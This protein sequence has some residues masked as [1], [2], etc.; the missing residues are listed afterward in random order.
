MYQLVLLGPVT[1]VFDILRNISFYVVSY[2]KAIY[3]GLLGKDIE[4]HY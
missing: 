2:G 1:S 3:S 4:E